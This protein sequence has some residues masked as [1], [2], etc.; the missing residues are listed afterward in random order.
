MMLSWVKKILERLLGIL[1][2]PSAAFL[3]YH[4]R[5]K[6]S[7]DNPTNPLCYDEL[8]SVRMAVVVQGPLLLDDNFTLETLRLYKKNFSSSRIILSTW[9]GED[10]DTIAAI[11][12]LSIE[13]IISKKPEKAGVANVNFQIASSA[14]GVRHASSLGC[15]YVLKTRTDQRI[16]SSQALSFCYLSVKRF[17]LLNIGSQRERIVAFNLNTFMYRP[18]SI[19]DMANFGHIDD[20]EK[21]WCIEF[22]TREFEGMPSADTLLGW[23]KLQLAEVYFVSAFAKA[24][25]EELV[26]SLDGSWRFIAERF[27]ILNTY[28]IDLYWRKYTRREFRHE[29]YTSLKDRQ[30]NFSDWLLLQSGMPNSVPEELIVSTKHF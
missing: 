7:G 2:T 12:R 30:I 16:Y 17:P 14:A 19:S 13:V 8:D 4:S 23:S 22:D 25:G 10:V 24:I 21:Y 11:K 1:E 29:N 26:W 18:Y 20:M 15:E 28:D 9:E 6:F 27:C 5:P 3:T